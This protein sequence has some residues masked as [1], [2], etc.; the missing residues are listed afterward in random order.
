[1]L[2]TLSIGL[3]ASALAVASLPAKA[4]GYGSASDLGVM[5]IQLKDVVKPSIGLQGA[6]QGAGT[7]NQIGVG[8]FIPLKINKNSLWFAD[9]QAKANFADFDGYSS[10]IN[11]D[12]DGL[13]VSTSSRVGY[14]WLNGDRS[15]MFGV[16]G[17]YDS[18][19]MNTGGTDT[20]RRVRDKKSVFFQ[21]AA[22][23]LEAAEQAGWS[24]NSY[25]LI[26]FGDIEQ[27]I[28]D[29]YLAGALYTYGFDVS[30]QVS[31]GLNLTAGYYYQLNDMEHIHGSGFRTRVS[32]D[33][34][35]RVTAGVSYSYDDGYESR[36]S[37]DIRIALG[38]KGHNKRNNT[39]DS[40]IFNSLSKSPEHRDVRVHDGWEYCMDQTVTAS[41]WEECEAKVQEFCDEN[42]AGRADYIDFLQHSPPQPQPCRGCCES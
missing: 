29:C 42:N 39:D 36:V 23:S 21:Q 1:M 13:T 41:T 35:R 32:Y 25:A 9:I 12:V 10:I 38:P 30:R 7:P 37:G 20:G 3:M 31:S 19:P 17:G 16:H 11:T 22:L 26:P 33:L 5:S 14:R 24:F 40:F 34:S 18:R 15:W 6:L 28:N 8:G 27:R 4:D 2:R